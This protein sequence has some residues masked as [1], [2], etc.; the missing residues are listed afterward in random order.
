[1]ARSRLG[2]SLGDLLS[3][4]LNTT[5]EKTEPI[6]PS[7]TAAANLQELAIDVIQGG[8]FQPRRDMDSAALEELASSIK[9]QGILQ[10]LLVRP[11]DEHR[12]E[13]IAGERR[14]KAAQIAGLSQVPVIIKTIDDQ[15]TMALALIENIQREDLSPLDEALA[16]ERLIED[17]QLTHDDAAALLG[18]SRAQITNLLRLLNLE[19]QVKQWLNE[20]KLDIGHAKVLL[21]LSG[22]MQL[23]A[24]EKVLAQGLTVRQTEVLVAKTKHPLSHEDLP[25]PKTLT[26]DLQSL[27]AR[28]ANAF[29]TKALIK[30]GKNGQGKLVLSYR[31]SAQL[32]QWLTQLQATAMT[33]EE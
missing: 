10:P 31:N 23:Q 9:A 28:F 32:I 14:F 18:K 33:T 20:K 5:I 11:L 4:T 19:P 30:Q 6:S 15:T 29:T 1:M 25:H 17:C 16:I 26:P 22:R 24:A 21:S 13:I 3:N 7:T 27:Q 2:R 12:Y 8:Q